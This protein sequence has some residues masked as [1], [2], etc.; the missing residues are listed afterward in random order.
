MDGSI[1]PYLCR[2]IIRPAV[3]SDISWMVEMMLT[4]RSQSGWDKYTREGFNADSLTLFIAEQL[5]NPNSV[6]IVSGNSA[7]C[8]AQLHRFILPPHMPVMYEWAWCGHPKE[9]VRC[10]R[11]ACVWGKA[12]GAELAGR[13]TAKPSDSRH[14]TEVMTWER[15]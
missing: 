4:L 11:V 9:A 3:P 2:G 6:C 14:I 10:W 12:K 15:L 8:G 13:T 5:L 7:F 1:L